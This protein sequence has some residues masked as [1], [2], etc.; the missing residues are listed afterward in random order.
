MMYN[1]ELMMA[2]W[3]LLTAMAAGAVWIYVKRRRERLDQDVDPE[4]YSQEP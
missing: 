4:S 1:F 2:G 3:V